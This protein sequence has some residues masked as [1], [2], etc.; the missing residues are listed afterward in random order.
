MCSLLVTYNFLFPR[1]APALGSQRFRLQLQFLFC[2]LFVALDF[3]FSVPCFLLSLGWFFFWPRLTQ[4]SQNN[5]GDA[6]GAEKEVS[7]A[8]ACVTREGKGKLWQGGAGSSLGARG[9]QCL[10]AAHLLFWGPKRCDVPRPVTM[11][12]SDRGASLCCL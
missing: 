10:R 9:Q 7:Q 11:D 3:P 6:E 1:S 4:Q 8:R 12:E 5:P 2:S